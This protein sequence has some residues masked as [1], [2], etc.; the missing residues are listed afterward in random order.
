METKEIDLSASGTASV[1][2]SADDGMVQ[3][4]TAYLDEEVTPEE[5]VKIGEALIE[6]GKAEVATV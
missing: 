2:I 5:A 3:I 6:A 1:T 4:R